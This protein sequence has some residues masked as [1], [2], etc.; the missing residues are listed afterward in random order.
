ME[1]SDLPLFR[2]N[3]I[4]IFG[5]TG[6][7]CCPQAF[8]SCGE[9]ELLSR[10]SAWASHCC[11]FRH[12]GFSSGGSLGSKRG[13]SNC[14]AWVLLLYCMWGW[15]RIPCIGR[16]IPIHC[17]TREVPDLHPSSCSFGLLNPF[18]PLKPHILEPSRPP[19]PMLTCHEF[20][21]SAH[22]QADLCASLCS[23]LSVFLW[24]DTLYLNITWCYQTLAP[25]RH[26]PIVPPFIHSIIYLFNKS[27][28]R[29]WLTVVGNSHYSLYTQTPYLWSPL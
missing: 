7:H 10:S 14:G 12:V 28:L 24:W 8:S 17:A 18:W 19:L 1:L 6:L 26:I 21:W 16:P 25:P 3:F 20:L 23:S 2:N 29:D 27:L 15:T 9:W 11:G 22:F 13:F 4:F 5:C